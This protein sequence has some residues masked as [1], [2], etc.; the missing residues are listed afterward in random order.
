MF[1]LVLICSW[2]SICYNKIKWLIAEAWLCDLSFRSRR[3][4][5]V[6]SIQCTF[7][8]KPTTCLSDVY[9]YLYC[10]TVFVCCCIYCVLMAFC[11]MYFEI[12]SKTLFFLDLVFFVVNAYELFH[13]QSMFGLLKLDSESNRQLSVMDEC[14][15]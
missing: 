5:S 6:C 11:F 9:S 12:N 2:P 4:W 14:L 10:I 8:Q 3:L 15:P 7:Y 13:Q 1:C